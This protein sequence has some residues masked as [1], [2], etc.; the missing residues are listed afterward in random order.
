MS[1]PEAMHTLDQLENAYGRLMERSRLGRKLELPKVVRICAELRGLCSDGYIHQCITRFQLVCER[2][3]RLNPPAEDQEDDDLLLG[4]QQLRILRDQFR[5][6][7]RLPLGLFREP[8]PAQE[9]QQ[10]S[11]SAPQSPDIF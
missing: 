8:W 3:T 11:A 6:L 1:T 5:Y 7:N 10:P 2:L 9:R 4:L